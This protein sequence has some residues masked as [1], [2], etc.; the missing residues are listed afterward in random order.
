M[1]RLLERL[2]TRIA[3][4]LDRSLL[5]V[6]EVDDEWPTPV[7]RPWPAQAGPAVT[8]ADQHDR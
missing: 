6:P 3:D 1:S 4:A 8:A 7:G 5:T 2:L